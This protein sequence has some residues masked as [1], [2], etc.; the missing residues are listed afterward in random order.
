[1]LSLYPGPGWSS[2]AFFSLLQGWRRRSWPTTKRYL[3]L[4]TFAPANIAAFKGRNPGFIR[5]STSPWWCVAPLSNGKGARAQ[6]RRRRFQENHMLPS[7]RPG[8]WSARVSTIVVDTS[9]C[10]CNCCPWRMPLP[11]S[12]RRTAMKNAASHRELLY[13]LLFAASGAVLSAFGRDPKRMGGQHGM[14]GSPESEQSPTPTWPGPRW[15]PDLARAPPGGKG[16]TRRDELCVK[17][18][19]SPAFA[20]LLSVDEPD[21]SNGVP[22]VRASRL[23]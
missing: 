17:C 2:A 15:H 7:N 4:C 10:P 14:T 20:P 16:L 3:K 19:F 22:V 5:W 12:S 11:A 23:W 18:A 13:P 21:A 6:H 1:M 8:W 9:A